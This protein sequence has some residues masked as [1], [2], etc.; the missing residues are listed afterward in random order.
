MAKKNPIRAVNKRSRRKK[1]NKSSVWIVTIIV[2]LIVLGGSFWVWKRINNQPTPSSSFRKLVPK[3]F[4]TIGIDVSHHQ[5]E[6]NWD[7][8]FNHTGYDSLIHF[9][10]CKSTEGN[11]HIDT[12][13]ERNRKVLNT[14][15]IPNGA[16]H[17]FISK[18]PPRPQAEHFLK[19][20]KKRDIDLPPVLDVE[21][22]GFSDQDL[23]DKMKIWLEVVEQKTGMRPIIYTPLNFY[24]NKFKSAFLNY[25]F[26]IAAYS[27]KPPCI[28]DDRIIH[29]QFS[30]SGRIP[31]TKE[32]VDL[33]VSKLIY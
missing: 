31:G 23:I 18:D 25:K 6:M 30:E 16:Y 2:A 32:K 12:Q 9:V 1:S 10:Y 22:E 13:W 21:M 14:L 29:W 11:T 7:K 15:G 27:K 26:W 33:N 24:E 19:H 4:P 17:F 8:L 5:G 28:E 3:G 20:W